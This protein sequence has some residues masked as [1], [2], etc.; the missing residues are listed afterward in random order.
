[1]RKLIT[2]G[3]TALAVATALLAGAGSAHAETAQVTGQS[4]GVGIVDTASHAQAA[5]WTYENW[6]FSQNNCFVG[7][8]ELFQSDPSVIQTRCEPQTSGLWYLYALR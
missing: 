1:M 8:N 6:Y 4:N 2:R 7:S 3:I 5:G